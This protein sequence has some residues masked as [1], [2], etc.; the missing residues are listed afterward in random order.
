MTKNRIDLLKSVMLVMLTT[1]FLASG[2]WVANAVA[3]VF[4]GIAAMLV[5]N[6]NTTNTYYAKLSKQEI[7]K[8]LSL[9]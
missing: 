1:L 2:P 7:Q 9:V 3:L 6:F 5:I 4:I 8:A